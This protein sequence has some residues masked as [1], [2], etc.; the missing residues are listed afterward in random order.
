M[1][2][3]LVAVAGNV[4]NWQQPSLHHFPRFVDP[5][6]GGSISLLAGNCRMVAAAHVQDRL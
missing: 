5:G 3:M 1:S 2:P 4:I 6:G